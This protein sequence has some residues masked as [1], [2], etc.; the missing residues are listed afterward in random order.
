MATILIGRVPSCRGRP[1]L[2]LRGNESLA[3]VDTAAHQ[4][5]DLAS[6]VATSTRLLVGDLLIF[7]CRRRQVVVSHYWF[8]GQHEFSYSSNV[9]LL[10]R[11]LRRNLASRFGINWL[12]SRDIWSFSKSLRNFNLRI[13]NWSTSNVTDNLLTTSSR[14]RCSICNSYIR[15]C[16]DCSEKFVTK[17]FSSRCQQM[18]VRFYA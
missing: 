11:F 9:S 10:C 14:S 4:S 3:V 8:G 7:F 13:I 18:G 17:L 2:V 6:S 5:T 12:L 16:I 15:L 1:Q